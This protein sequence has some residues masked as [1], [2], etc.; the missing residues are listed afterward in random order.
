MN[1]FEIVQQLE[2]IAADH[3]A[4]VFSLEYALTMARAM[5]EA[6]DYDGAL[7]EID[8]VLNKN[9]ALPGTGLTKDQLKTWWLDRQATGTRQQ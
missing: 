1:I 2:D 3:E 7:L 6:G 9:R 8:K 5:I 4:E